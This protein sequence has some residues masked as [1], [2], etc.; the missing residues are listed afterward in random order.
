MEE[1]IQVDEEKLEEYDCVRQRNGLLH[2]PFHP[3]RHRNS[4]TTSLLSFAED[5]P[6]PTCPPPIVGQ[7]TT[8]TTSPRSQFIAAS[9]KTRAS[10][11][12]RS[13]T[14]ATASAQAGR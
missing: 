1:M 11:I 5:S 8:A 10:V 7:F 12:T 4:V 9:P 13:M 3:T 14:P 2:L 6:P